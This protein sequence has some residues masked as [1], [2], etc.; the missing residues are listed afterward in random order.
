MARILL[1]EQQVI[2]REAIRHFLFPEHEVAP[3]EEWPTDQGML[4]HAAAIVDVETLATMKVSQHEAAAELA[5]AQIRT[6][7][8][9]PEGATLPES[10]TTQVIVRKPLAPE[11]LANALQALLGEQSAA[12]D[13]APGNTPIAL[14]EVI[15]EPK[16]AAAE[17][18][19]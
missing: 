19:N 12:R 16:D 10:S 15:D 6:L 5:T 13:P 8:I 14:T 17:E 2:V 18:T 1:I 9:Y 3:R 11:L 4:G 7:W